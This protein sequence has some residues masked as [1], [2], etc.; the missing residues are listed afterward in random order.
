M[1]ALND[2]EV[3]LLNCER[4][5]TIE[6]EYSD[7]VNKSDDISLL[8]ILAGRDEVPKVKCFAQEFIPNMDDHEFRRHFRVGKTDYNFLFSE[9]ADALVRKD[10]GHG[11]VSPAKQLLV[12]LWHISNLESVRETTST[13]QGCAH[14]DTKDIGNRANKFLKWPDHDR[15]QEILVSFR[16]SMVFPMLQE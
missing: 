15:R 9:F 5:C 12:F 3:L 8:G 4:I 1:A 14:S 13:V 6:G 11:A 10:G 7:L 16:L 2:A